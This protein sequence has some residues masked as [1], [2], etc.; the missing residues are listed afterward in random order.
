MKR[1]N[2]EDVPKEG[3]VDS[4]AGSSILSMDGCAIRLNFKKLELILETQSLK[5][6][7]V[8]GLDQDGDTSGEFYQNNSEEYL[9]AVRELAHPPEFPVGHRNWESLKLLNV[10]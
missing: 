1:V 6:V 5:Q 7:Q 2:S 4:G 3:Q 8:M 9:N 10:A